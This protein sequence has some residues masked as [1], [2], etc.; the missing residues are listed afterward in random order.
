[1]TLLRLKNRLL[2]LIFTAFPSLSVRWAAQLATND[3]PIPWISPRKSL[4]EATVALISTGGVHLTSDPPFAMN[5]PE[6]DPSLRRIPLPANR[7]TLT[8]TH[9][10]YD[11]RDAEKDLNLVLPIDRLQELDE[12]GIIGS[13]HPTVYSL[14]GHIDGRHLR[15]LREVTARQI[16]RE[17]LEARVDYALLVPA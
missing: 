3:E 17:L 16:A 15:T 5:D 1:M 4:A 6:G 9:D 2:A 13:L 11:H 14:M 8:I 7:E 12:R 10:Y